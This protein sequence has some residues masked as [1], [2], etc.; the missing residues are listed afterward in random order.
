MNKREIVLKANEVASRLL[1]DARAR[2]RIQDGYTRIDPLAIAEFCEVAVNFQK[3][4]TLLGAFMENPEPGILVNKDRPA[5][6]VYM[7]TAHELGHFALGHG[8]KADQVE[9]QFDS[10]DLQEV[11]ADAFAAALLAPR[12]LL[13]STI[14]DRRLRP[15]QLRHPTI[16]YQLSLRLGISYTAMLTTLVRMKILAWSD[17][18][19]LRDHQPQHAKT[20]ALV[21]DQ[22]L[23]GHADVWVLNEA[24]KDHVLEPRST[25]RFVLDVPNHLSAGYLWTLDEARSEGFVLI[26]QQVSDPSA[27]DRAH[28]AASSEPL[29]RYALERRGHRV[30]PSADLVFVEKQPW[31]ERAEDDIEFHLRAQFGDFTDGLTEGTKRRRIEAVRGDQ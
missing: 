10:E 20:V 9:D 25:D 3:L 11:G 13:A 21:N 22:Q 30:I 26:P 24:D 2:V 31:R 28:A 18:A 5:G 4:R 23:T 6:L 27:A 19:P 1:D 12:W 16:L 29:A 15:D 14:R 7:T 17:A 8:P